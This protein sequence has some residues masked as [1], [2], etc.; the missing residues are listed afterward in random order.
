M[1]TP[2]GAGAFPFIQLS[3]LPVVYQV[4]QDGRGSEETMTAPARPLHATSLPWVR[5]LPFWLVALGLGL[6]S[7]PEARSDCVQDPDG[8]VALTSGAVDVDA[9]TSSEYAA[10]PDV[11]ALPV[12]D[13]IDLQDA[14]VAVWEAHAS[15][16]I[17]AVGSDTNQFKMGVTI[18][19]K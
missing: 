16:T 15:P 3:I 18:P 2:S 11:S 14:Y 1:Q 8:Y 19:R 9:W 13:G 17:P 4:F 5:R 6:L 7:E 10:R 12:R